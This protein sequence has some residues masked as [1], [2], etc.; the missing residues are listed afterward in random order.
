MV[1][2]AQVGRLTPWLP[3]AAAI[4]VAGL[5][6]ISPSYRVYG[7]AF[8]S[9]TGGNRA[10]YSGVGTDVSGGCL[11]REL[12]DIC[13]LTGKEV[14]YFQPFD[15]ITAKMQLLSQGGNTVAVLDDSDTMLYLATGITPWPRYSPIIPSLSPR[16]L[17]VFLQKLKN[18]PPDYVLIRGTADHTRFFNSKVPWTAVHGALPATFELNGHVGPFEVWRKRKVH[19]LAKVL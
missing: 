19:R 7:S 6:G 2:S 8:K 5:I 18:S 9:L 13:G 1:I 15:G 10:A 14:H 3:G 12:H 11:M 4:V 16:R 17:A